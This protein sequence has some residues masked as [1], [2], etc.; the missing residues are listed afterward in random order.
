MPQRDHEWEQWGLEELV[1]NLR[2]YTDRNPSPN[3]MSSK[4]PKGSQDSDRRK[5]NLLLASSHNASDCIYCGSIQHRSNDCN[6]ILDVA[7][8]GEL[9]K[10]HIIMCYNC[11]RSWHV[12][13][14]C[15]SRGLGRSGTRHHTS[16]CDKPATTTL[17]SGGT[18]ET[19][20][21]RDN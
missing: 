6:K 17:S 10:K 2:N 5:D 11:T 1:E 20:W 7:S 8:R 12:A 18:V 16:L 15:G 19:K 14:E 4:T 9:L 13:A 21:S 3:E